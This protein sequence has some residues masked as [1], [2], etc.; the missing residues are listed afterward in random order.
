MVQL[1]ISVILNETLY[2]NEKYVILH[3]R[4]FMEKCQS[5]K[6]FSMPTYVIFSIAALKLLKNNVEGD[7][8]WIQ[9]LRQVLSSSLSSNKSHA[10][11]S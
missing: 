3:R 8:N 9:R 1:L 2:L 5:C 4:L 11:Q 10:I 6:C 7:S